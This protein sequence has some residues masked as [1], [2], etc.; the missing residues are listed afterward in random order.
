MANSCSTS[1]TFLPSALAG[2]EKLHKLDER[3]TLTNDPKALQEVWTNDAVRLGDGAID[4]D[5]DS[6]RSSN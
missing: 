6:N 5:N 4:K 2:I 3:V 1:S